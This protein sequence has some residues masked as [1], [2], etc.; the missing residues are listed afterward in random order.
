MPAPAEPRERFGEEGCEEG[1]AESPGDALG[2]EFAGLRAD[3]RAFRAEVRAFRAQWARQIWILG[4][5]LAT[6][7]IGVTAAIIAA[8]AFMG[9]A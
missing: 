1:L 3:L 8:V 6:L 5:S 4:L 9:G 2:A 7:I